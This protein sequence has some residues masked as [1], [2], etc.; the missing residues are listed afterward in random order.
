[1]LW[2]LLGWCGSISNIQFKIRSGFSKSLTLYAYITFSNAWFIVN[3]TIKVF[4]FYF[5]AKNNY[6]VIKL[7]L[8]KK[9]R[10][11]SAALSLG[12]DASL[13]MRS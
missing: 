10:H 1:M 3:A 2:F 11:R 5:F 12:K 7:K 6:K 9:E 13:R 4:P 8:T